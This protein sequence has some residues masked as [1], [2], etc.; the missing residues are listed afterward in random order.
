MKLLNSSFFAALLL[1]IFVNQVSAQKDWANFARYRAANNDLP[2]PLKSENRVV[3][4]GN[5]ITDA[6]SPDFFEN[7][8]YINRGISGQTNP[9][10]LVRLDRKSVV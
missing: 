3:F 4:M 7:K 2:K 9:Q 5:S 8:P 6:W 1:L 10:M